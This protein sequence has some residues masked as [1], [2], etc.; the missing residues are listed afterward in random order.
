M[1][2]HAMT[3]DLNNSSTRHRSLASLEKH[4]PWPIGIMATVFPSEAWSPPTPN[5]E[6]LG[7]LFHLGEWAL[8]SI[9]VFGFM[10]L[11]ATIDDVPNLKKLAGRLGRTNSSR[12][13]RQ[14]RR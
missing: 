4:G 2:R 11:D 9:A 6:N 8:T 13:F 10:A 1:K 3:E 5:T 14:R 7:E 12:R